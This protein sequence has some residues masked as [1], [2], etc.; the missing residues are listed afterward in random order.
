MRVHPLLSLTPL[1]GAWE[2]WA[3]APHGPWC[4]ARLSCGMGCRESLCSGHAGGLWKVWMCLG[5]PPRSH[6]LSL[7]VSSGQ[8]GAV[9]GQEA[10]CPLLTGEGLAVPG[11]TLRDSATVLGDHHTYRVFVHSS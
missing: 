10:L 3:V 1:E 6:S 2:E 8:D 7:H 5:A 11:G 4:G 9:A